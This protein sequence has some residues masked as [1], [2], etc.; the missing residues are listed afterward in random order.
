MEFMIL[1]ILFL[2][3]VAFALVVSIHRSHQISQAQL[4]LESKKVLSGVAD[5]INTAYLEGDGFSI[6]VTLPERILRMN[7]T[8]NIS[9][10]E[11]IL[12]VDGNGYIR[13]LLT[14]NVKVLSVYTYFKA[15]TGAL[16]QGQGAALR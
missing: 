13:Y 10:N 11:V 7:Y 5:R 15:F 3:A 8:I 9:N 1:F 14:D 4:D 2:V 6:A 12:K 16:E